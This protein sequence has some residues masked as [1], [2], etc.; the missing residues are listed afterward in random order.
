[1]DSLVVAWAR[2]EASAACDWLAAM[3]VAAHL[4]V[5]VEEVSLP[6]VCPRCGSAGHGIPSVVVRDVPGP[7]AVSLSRTA[8]VAVAAVWLGSAGRRVGVDV[9]RVAGFRGAGIADV[10]LHPDERALGPRDLA[11]TWVRKEALLKAAGTGLA[12][13]PASVRVSSA[14]KAPEIL[15]WPCGT[16]SQEPRWLLDLDL[17]AGL[18][19]AVAGTGD[20]PSQVTVRREVVAA[21]AGAATRRTAR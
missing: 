12:V 10:L 9:E 17:D 15:R 20:G 2:T 6:R 11:T 19:A 13:D 5:T 8:G 1:M 18:R 7:A 21:P 16:R 4:D 3:E 14:R